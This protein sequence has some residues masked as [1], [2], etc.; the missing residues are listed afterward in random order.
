MG[1]QGV[2]GGMSG[3][4]SSTYGLPDIAAAKSIPW[5][6]ELD[7]GLRSSKLGTNNYFSLLLSLSDIALSLSL[8]PKLLNPKPLNSEPETSS[9]Y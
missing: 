1:E 7:R 5:N 4:G 6:V 2:A 8:S 3:G 9:K